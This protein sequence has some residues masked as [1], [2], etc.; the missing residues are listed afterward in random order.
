MLNIVIVCGGTGSI[1]LQKGLNFLYGVKQYNL[2]IVINAY[3]NGKSTG[4]CRHVF[5][6]KILGPSDLRKNQITLFECTYYK[7]LMNPNTKQFKL[8]D[9]FEMRFSASDHKQYYDIASDFIKKADYLSSKVKQQLLDF[10]DYFFF[11]RPKVYRKV[12]E[13]IEFINFSMSNIFYSSCA[14]L[15]HYSLGAA[16]TEMA[17]ILE[18]DDKVH[19]ISDV[20]LYLKAQTQS[21][22]IIED[23]ADIV[24]WDHPEDRI[25]RAML[26]KKNTEYVPTVDESNR[27]LVRDIFE[28]ADLIIF[29]SGTQWSSLIPTY[30]HL[31]FREMIE[32]CHA[33]K[34]L[35]MNNVA[36]HD[37]VGLSAEE[38]LQCIGKYLNL[39]QIT[40]VLNSNAE[41]AMSRIQCDCTSLRAE[42]SAPNSKTHIPEA[43][44]KT[45][46]KD[47]FGINKQ[48]CLISD[49]D[50]TLWDEMG[51]NHSQ[52]IGKENLAIFEGIIL[53]GNSYEH[54]RQVTRDYFVNRTGYPIYCDYGNTYFELSNQKPVILSRD[55]LI[56]DDLASDFECNDEFKGKIR[57]RGS[58]IL[59]IKPLLFREKKLD[60]IRSILKKYQEKYDAQI[61]GRTSIDIM[62]KGYSKKEMLNLIMK[63]H[64]LKNTDVLYIGNEL[65]EGNEVCINDMDIKTLQVNDVF[66]TFLFLKTYI[67]SN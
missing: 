22:H 6:D 2:D 57:I 37:M 45:I 31:G 42:L 27:I 36:D 66:E 9:L 61:A 32:N 25:V 10:L 3:D 26:Y 38:C 54:V 53:S 29:S 13:E 65:D 44:T 19:L 28:K 60:I 4:L 17:K 23:E 47:Y 56:N 34:Y 15:N 12:V 20:N 18:I 8:H 52:S 40:V 33:K 1:A 51:N 67:N 39:R 5:N 14:A 55:F 30:M 11:E 49:L 64:G 58:V 41:P 63:K 7:E 21:G 50:G 59:T 48:Y 35:I 46:M 43:I 62:V 16:G 24:S